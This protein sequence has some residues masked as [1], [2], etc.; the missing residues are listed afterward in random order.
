MRTVAVIGGS[1]HDT[2][3]GAEILA[4]LA[5]ELSLVERPVSE[6]P[7]A[8]T[9]FQNAE[10]A[11]RQRHMREVLRSVQAQGAAGA[12]IYCNS[13]SGAT[14]LPALSAELGLPLVTPLHAYR[15]WAHRY[16]ALGVM[17]AN[18]SGHAGIER[19]LLHANPQLRLVQFAQLDLADAVEEGRSA[20]A[21][22]QA[23]ALAELT[24]LLARLG[25]ESIVLGCTHFPA[26]AD[27]L[28]P[29]SPVPLLD[30]A[31]EMWR[32]LQAQLA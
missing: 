18:A 10:P 28:A 4:R 26:F 24:A 20:E 17:A 1:P 19:T 2:R 23:F 14:D 9:L 29:L 8:Q 21:I 32:Q 13:L 31:E 25:A 5:P 11:S 22:V 15:E 7:R 12:Y 3:L 30:P 6:S 27:A 16:R